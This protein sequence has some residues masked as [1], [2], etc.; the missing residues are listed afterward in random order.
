VNAG[1][2]TSIAGDSSKYYYVDGPALTARFQSAVEVLCSSDGQRILV[3]DEGSDLL[4]LIEH[5]TVTTIVRLPRPLCVAWDGASPLE[6]AVF[7]VSAGNLL[8]VTLPEGMHRAG[9]LR[10]RFI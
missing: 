9:P 10:L 8:R 1:Q 2:V 7:V 5:E 3:C 6:S 4:R